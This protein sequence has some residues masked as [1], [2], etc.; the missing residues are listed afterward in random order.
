MTSCVSSEACA[1]FLIWN[2]TSFCLVM[3]CV[4][5]KTPKCGSRNSWTPFRESE[6][7]WTEDSFVLA[8]GP[9]SRGGRP[10]HCT[11]WV[12]LLSPQGLAYGFGK[13]GEHD[14]EADANSC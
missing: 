4:S 8:Y 13:R 5:S 12:S 1:T 7:N 2:L 11:S 10:Y 14:V 3:G 9:R 6:K